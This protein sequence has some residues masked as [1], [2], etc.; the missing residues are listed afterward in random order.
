MSFN[1]NLEDLPFADVIQLLHV[2]RKSGTLYISQ[3][4]LK[5]SII[6]RDGDIIGAIHPSEN[7]N[8]GKIL[9]EQ[10]DITS[11]QL[12]EAILAAET[13]GDDRRP[14]LTTL[15]ELGHIQKEKGWK[16]LEI[17]IHRTM[18]EL[19]SWKKGT[20]TFEMDK[21]HVDDEFRHFPVQMQD[22]IGVDTQSALSAALHLF[23]E[24]NK[25]QQQERQKKREQQEAE[26][27]RKQTEDADQGEVSTVDQDQVEGTQ[28]DAGSAAPDPQKHPTQSDAP[29]AATRLIDL[30]GGAPE[31]AHF[32]RS[33]RPRRAILLCTDGYLKNTIKKICKD[34]NIYAFSSGIERDVNKEVEDC[35]AV[36]AAMV[37]VADLAQDT[38]PG[39][40]P[41]RRLG[42]VQRIKKRS[43]EI[44]LVILSN[45]F[46]VRA[47]RQSFEM[48]ARTMIP[49]PSR[50]GSKKDQY[51]P[52]MKRFVKVLTACLKS[53][54]EEESHLLKRTQAT[55]MQMESLKRRVNAIQDRKTSPDITLIVLQYIAEYMDRG[56]I[57][58]VRKDDLLG[59]GSFGMDNRGDTI[60]TAAM[61]LKIPLDRRSIFS[62]VVEKGIVFHGAIND[63]ILNEN[64]FDKIGSPA[65]PEV[66]LLPLKTENRTRALVYSDFG[67]R[68]AGPVETDALE[69]LASQAG[70]AMEIALQR[71]RPSM[72]KPK[73]PADI[74]DRS[75]RA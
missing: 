65:A 24:R 57:F 16:G 73:H 12:D 34:N 38:S 41:P 46:G 39:L 26:A 42:T 31:D 2:A 6:C 5:A 70:M 33:I 13:S 56:I 20:F 44:P 69:I 1:G 32:R 60:S 23:D 43:P 54:F 40:G 37:L 58:L 62:D 25:E 75:P 51:V 14:I 35:A 4:S 22:G 30:A 28:K 11:E 71:A 17:L 67:T 68:E 47:Y 8:L 49:K 53:I 15:V 63:P 7:V 55:R 74:D 3:D 59:L 29:P 9:M 21:L 64:L 36:G 66:L 18:A 72:S 52:L 27:A 45:S 10:G 61:R 50:K 48:G 19:V